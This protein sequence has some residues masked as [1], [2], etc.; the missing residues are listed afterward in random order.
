MSLFLV[1]WHGQRGRLSGVVELYYPICKLRCPCFLCPPKKQYFSMKHP[2]IYQFHIHGNYIAGD[3]ADIH[4]NP[5]ASFYPDRQPVS[6][7]NTP[8]IEE[9]APVR[10]EAAEGPYALAGFKYIHVSITESAER[11]Q[12][13]NTVCNIVRLPRMQQ[14]CDELYQLMKNRKVLCSIN[15]DAMLKELR[16]LGLPSEEG[17]SDKNFYYYFRVPPMD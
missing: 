6:K 15:P 12:I 3:Y 13:H 8:P 9:I 1:L 16:R 10:E 2:I 17:F 4:N 5:F 11:M 7:G 14:V